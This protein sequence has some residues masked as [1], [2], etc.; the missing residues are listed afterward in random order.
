MT[1]I[2][3]YKRPKCVHYTTG[4]LEQATIQRS[5]LNFLILK[6]TAYLLFRKF[7]ENY[8]NLILKTI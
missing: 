3:A 5:F 8:T 7:L 6:F 1:V 4:F 2:P